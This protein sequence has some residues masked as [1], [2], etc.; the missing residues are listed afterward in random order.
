MFNWAIRLRQYDFVIEYKPGITNQEADYLSCHPI[1]QLNELTEGTVL[2]LDAR[3]IEQAQKDVP[4]E[5][6][7]KRVKAVTEGDK[8]VLVYYQADQKKTF[9]PDGLA[10][11]AVLEL[12]LAKGHLGKKQL[13]L[14]F[15]RKYYNPCLGEII[16]YIVRNCKVCAQVKPVIMKY[17]TLGA[18]GPAGCTVLGRDKLLISFI[19]N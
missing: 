13:E 18:L 14:H 16:A 2:W 5:S 11:E 10:S 15:S 17:G 19:S 7:L 8:R 3:R 6:L 1:S 12:H 4:V 9:L